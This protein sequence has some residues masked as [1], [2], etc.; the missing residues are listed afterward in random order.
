MYSKCKVSSTEYYYARNW[1]ISICKFL[2]VK[3]IT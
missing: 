2:K 3:I 1:M